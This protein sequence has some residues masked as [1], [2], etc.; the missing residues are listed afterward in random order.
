MWSLIGY[1]VLRI[2]MIF[3]NNIHKTARNSYKELDLFPET[4]G[5]S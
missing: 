1:P 2:E 4:A 5:N 3:I